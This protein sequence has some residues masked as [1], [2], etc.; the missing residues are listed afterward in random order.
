VKVYLEEVREELRPWLLRELLILD[1]DFRVRQGERPSPTDYFTRF[2]GAGTSIRAAFQRIFSV[3]APAGSGH[4]STP[5]QSQEDRHSYLVQKALLSPANEW[6]HFPGREIRIRLEVV[7]GPH[8]GRSFLFDGHDNFIVGRASYA[9]FRLPHKDPYF[10][11]LHFL[12]ELN[13]PRCRLSDLG[14]TNGTMLNGQRVDSADLHDGDLIRGGDT[15]LKVSLEMEKE[16]PTAAIAGSASSADPAGSTTV[17][18]QLT[19]DK[20]EAGPVS[21]ATP[22]IAGFEILRELGRGG[23]GIVYLARRRKD[24]T[25]VAIKTIRP[26]GAVSARDVQRFLR[27]ASILSD[28]KHPNIVSFHEFG[29]LGEML[30]IVMDYIAGTS[31]ARLLAEEGPLAVPRAV[32]LICQALDALDFAHQHGFVHRDVKPA[33]LL[34][35]T[36]DGREVCKLADFGLARAYQATA[37]SGITL[38]GDVA[39]SLPFIAPE[40][41]T[42]YRQVQPSA[43]QY[44]AAATL[45]MLLTNHYLF[46]FDEIPDHR[47]LALILTAD[48]VPLLRRL[49]KSRIL[50]EEFLHTALS[51]DPLR[52]FPSCDSFRKS[53]LCFT[54][55][56]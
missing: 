10:S 8:Q 15:A 20:P 41:I 38:L 34:I 6:D 21:A 31:A 51:K 48:P 14:S 54:N 24:G 2:P 43:D 9:H 1:V 13:P 27:E 16:K 40:Q 44:S 49:P 26:Q 35:A 33:N 4:V 23:M 29:Q 7:E 45:Y 42:N 22:D 25:L 30:Y 50:L 53:L 37:M 36:E 12:I 39:G 17:A 46:D 55:N 47:R 56:F 52:R 32:R 3:A 18:M 28:L 11:R 5:P 19:I